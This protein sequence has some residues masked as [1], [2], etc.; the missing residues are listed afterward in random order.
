V[1]DAKSQTPFV[2]L[3]NRMIVLL[4]RARLGMYI[5]GNIGYF[6]DKPDN[7]IRFK[8]GRFFSGVEFR[9][10]KVSYLWIAICKR[11]VFL[12]YMLAEK[13]LCGTCL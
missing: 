8:L 11:K 7:E 3:V 5:I 13:Y 9:N 12:V 2:K 1:I 10:N 6:E 4:S